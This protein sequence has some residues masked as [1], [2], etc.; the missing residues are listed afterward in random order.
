MQIGIQSGAATQPHN[1]SSLA[2]GGSLSPTLTGLAYREIT[3]LL[4]TIVDVNAT[5]RQTGNTIYTKLK[6][7]TIG[8][9]QLGSVTVTYEAY[10]SGGT[11]YYNIRK[12]GVSLDEQSE[13][14]LSPV[15]HNYTITG[16]FAVGDT[17]EIWCRRVG[18]AIVYVENMHLEYGWRIRYFGDG[19]KFVLTSPLSLTDTEHLSVTASDP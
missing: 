13:T 10:V 5:M 1:H 19:T 8:A 11:G 2:Q 16:P 7:F 12:N 17:I 9:D 4:T 14:S 15:V 6:Q 3:G 18:G